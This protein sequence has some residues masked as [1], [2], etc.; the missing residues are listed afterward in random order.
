MSGIPEAQL[1]TW[2]QIGATTSA[3][4]TY[5]SVKA[6]LGAA[7]W[8]PQHVPQVYLQGSYR[9]DTNVY[10]ESDVDVVVELD[11]VWHRDLSGLTQQQV[12]AYHSAHEAASYEWQHLHTDTLSALRD[13]FGPGA[14]SIGR[15]SIKVDTPH[16]RADVIVAIQHRRYLR[17]IS[18]TDQNF[19]PGITLHIRPENRWIVSYPKFHYDNGVLKSART[20]GWYKPTVRI[21]KNARR[22]LV[23]QGTL[24][25]DH[26]PSYAI[27]CLV[28]S[29][30]D[31]YFGPTYRDTFCNVVNW[32][33]AGNVPGIRRVSEQGICVGNGPEQWPF[34]N[35]TLFLDA[36]VALWNGWT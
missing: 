33:N 16:R 11:N 4:R 36:L 24:N 19:V 20:N 34:A 31:N 15:K 10:A 32:A 29:V 1:T 28:Y 14:V 9:N 25:A 23:E 18:T 13:Y 5:D 27:E 17:F 22:Y 30:P 21:L 26:A 6:A 7:T 8:N 3:T 35:A 2:S 12:A